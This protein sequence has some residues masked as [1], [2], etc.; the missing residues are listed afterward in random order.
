[1]PVSM[2]VPLTQGKVG[3]IDVVD[4]HLLAGY[5]WYTARAGKQW[6]MR[7]QR[8]RATVPRS[9]RRCI[10]FHRLLFPETKMVDHKNGN[11][12]D[13]RRE[14][15]RPAT[16]SQN[17]LNRAKRQGCSSRYKGVAWHIKHERWI[18]NIRYQG[19]RIHLG[20][21]FDEESA[22]RAYNEKALELFGDFAR[23]NIVP[24]EKEA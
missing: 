4:A 2:T 13:N 18:S 23:L 7:G 12:L 8:S 1:M 24:Q 21:F 19:R 5:R 22:A 15:I 14:N 10:D 11:G 17:Q 20:W 16:N 9:Q 3:L 6:Y